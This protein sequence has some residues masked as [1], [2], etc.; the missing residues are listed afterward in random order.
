VGGIGAPAALARPIA[1]T[2]FFAGEA[3]DTEGATGTVHGPPRSSCVRAANGASR[4]PQSVAE[5][6]YRFLVARF[7]LP[8]DVRGTLPPFFRVS[9]S[10]IAM[11][12]LRLFTFFPEP[13]VSVPFFRR[14]IVDFTF[15]EAALPYFAISAP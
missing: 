4:P 6:G 7:R 10:A 1:R 8:D 9:L 13:L 11:A 12:C 5:P 14:R 3:T 2:L 15:F